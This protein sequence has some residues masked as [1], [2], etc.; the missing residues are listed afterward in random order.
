M[1]KKSYFYLFITLL[2]VVAIATTRAVKTYN[3]YIE[4]QKQYSAISANE[5]F[6]IGLHQEQ[7]S[8][9]PKDEYVTSTVMLEKYTKEQEA[10]IPQEQ[11]SEDLLDKKINQDFNGYMQEFQNLEVLKGKDLRN[12]SEQDRAMLVQDPE[13][14]QLVLKYSKD[15]EFLKFLQSIQTK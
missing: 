4:K 7:L 6:M 15:P 8:S 11:T 14:Q 13:F 5:N 10:Q 1:S 2:C 12:M 3:K 9:E